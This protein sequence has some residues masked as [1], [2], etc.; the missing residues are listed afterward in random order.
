V[1]FT[2][3][4]AAAAVTLG[5]SACASDAGSSRN[6]PALK[7]GGDAAPRTI[8]IADSQSADK[9]SAL[10]LAQ[11]AAQVEAQSN[12]SITVESA[13]EYGS[14]TDEAVIEAVRD[15]DVQMAMVPARAWSTAGVDSMRVLQ[16]PFLVQSEAHADAIARDP[17]IVE[18]LFAGLDELGV[19]GVTMLPE[20]L[21]HLFSYT[22]PILTPDDVEGRHIRYLASEEV[23]T[24]LSTLGATPVD[25]G[26][27]EYT[28]LVDDGTIT[29]FDSSFSIATTSNPYPATGTA[30]L[31][32]YPKVVTFVANSEFWNGLAE[33]QRRLLTDAAEAMQDWAITNRPGEA[34]AAA[35]YCAEEGNAVNT[36]SESLAA[37]RQ[38]V[39]PIY[40]NL[41]LDPQAAQLIETIEALAP[42]TV[43]EPAEPCSH[44]TPAAIS[45]DDIV[46][47]GGDLPDGVYRIEFTDEYLRAHGMTEANVQYNHGIWTFRLDDGR[48]S[49]DQAA[50][51]VTGHSEGIYQVDGNTL[52]WRFENENLGFM[53]LTWS[54]DDDGALRFSEV[55]PGE[56][57][58]FL[59]DLPWPRIGD[60]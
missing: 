9:P 34:E 27:D 11:F 57:P 32:L 18:D 48:W 30:N 13:L 58:A 39:E 12:G 51:N 53:Q 24:I 1:N 59:F 45:Y 54:V 29:G 36:D 52:Y 41:T 25:T 20:A 47:A 22:S 33:D 50:P 15:G 31:T 21:R 35:A 60:L 37:F 6:D 55:K 19:H 4:A 38:A 5:F 28:A 7:A 56:V 40:D 43:D 16:A 26:G 3:L 46:P 2:R 23:A 8:T 17:A 10:A 14:G 42:P 44:T 49:F